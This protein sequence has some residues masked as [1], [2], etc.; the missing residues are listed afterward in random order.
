MPAAAQRSATP[1]RRSM[2]V[3]RKAGADPPAS[4]WMPCAP[5]RE[6]MDAISGVASAG[7]CRTRSMPGT[8]AP[9]GGGSSAHL[10]RGNVPGSRLRVER[11]RRRSGVVSE[12]EVDLR[13]L[14]IDARHRHAHATRELEHPAAAFAQHGVA[15]GIEMEIVAAELR[16]V[17]EAVDVEAIERDEDA[18]ARH[19]ADRAVEALADLVLHEIAL[20]PVLDVAGR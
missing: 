9:R 10:A 5:A 8:S 1:S 13:G 16:H 3:R 11:G 20:E 18:E 19:A 7:P 4:A 2:R 14:E 6:A 17:H 12:G 15:R